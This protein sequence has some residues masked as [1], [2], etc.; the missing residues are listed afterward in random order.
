M[1]PFFMPL[2]KAAV[3]A[4]ATKETKGSVELHDLVAKG[5]DVAPITRG[6]LRV[7][8]EDLLTKLGK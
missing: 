1:A 2:R 3:D 4:E 5:N 6:E 7:I 8:L